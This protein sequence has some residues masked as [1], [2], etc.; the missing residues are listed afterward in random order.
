MK[1]KITGLVH[2]VFDVVHYGHILH[3]KEARKKVDY[4]VCSVT[5]DSY[6][7]KGPQRPVFNIKERII[8]LESLKFFDKVI[9][10]NELTAEKN[11][12]LLKPDYYFKGI[13]YEKNKTDQNLNKEIRVLKNNGGKVYFTKTKTHSSSKIINNNFEFLKNSTITQIKKLRK[14]IIKFNKKK[15]I[16]NNSSNILIGEN[17]IDKY[18]FTQISGKSN[19]SPIVSTLKKKEV[20]YA[21]G[22]IVV[23]NFFAE[24]LNNISVVTFSGK[25]FTNSIKKYLNKNIKRLMIKIINYPIIKTRILDIYSKNK[26]FQITENEDFKIEKSSITKL[27]KFINNQANLYENIIFFNYGYHLTDKKILNSLKKFK[28]KILINFQTN[29]YNYGFN[30]LNKFP[31]AKFVSMDELEFRLAVGDKHTNMLKLIKKNLSVLNNYKTSIIT[32]GKNGAY[33]V[34][35]KKIQHFETIYDDLIDTTGCGDIFMST[36]IIYKYVYKF[37]SEF[38]MIVSHIAAGIHGNEIGNKLNLNSKKLNNVISKIIN[39]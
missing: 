34:E 24:F 38:S 5:S 39:V 35:N 2:G 1:K 23:A 7:D 22:I 28:S 4:L 20:T 18:L 3:F 25:D 19:K 6:V 14:D 36:F 8:F 32:A 10:S 30:L 27:V 17:I 13:E 12:N 26:L 11:I 21:G 33:L 29:S 31:S 16:K 15:F 37:S 9:I